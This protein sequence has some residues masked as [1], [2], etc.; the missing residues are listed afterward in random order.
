M[1]IYIVCGLVWINV[2]VNRVEVFGRL[3][4]VGIAI[5]QIA[6]GW[7]TKY[8]S[9]DLAKFTKPFLTK[10]HKFVT[11]QLKWVP[12]AKRILFWLT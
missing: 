7:K 8:I 12:Q 5:T 4:I 2:S 1:C 9:K 11:S 6:I 10:L 3:A